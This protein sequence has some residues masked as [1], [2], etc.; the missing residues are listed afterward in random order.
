MKTLIALAV[1]VPALA[2]SSNRPNFVFILIDDLGA[3]DTSVYGSQLYPTPNIDRLAAEGMRFTQAYAAAALCSPTRASILTG[4][5][6][7]RLHVTNWIPGHIFP[8]AKLRHPDWKKRLPPERLTIA[9]ALKEHG[10]ATAMIGKWHLSGGPSAPENQ[11]F[12]VNIA[13][14]HDLLGGGLPAAA[15]YF[16]PYENP[17]LKDGPDGEYLTDR[18]TDEAI[19]WLEQTRDRP[20]FLYLSH[21]AVHTPI[22]GKPKLVAKH[23]ARLEKGQNAAYAA[24]IE[25]VDESVGRISAALDRLD[26]TANTVVV[27]FSD[28]GG[29][30]RVSSNAPLRAGKG[31]PYEG[32]IREPLIVRW[33]GEIAPGSVCDTPVISTDFFPTFLD[34]A[35]LP[36]RPEHHRDGLSLVPLLRQSGEIDRDTLYWH[37]PHYHIAPPYGVVRQNDWKLIHFDEDQ[38]S[39]LYHL[40]EDPFEKSDLAASR[41]EMVERLQAI[42]V[43]WRED[44]GAQMPTPNPDHDPAKPPNRMVDPAPY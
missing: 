5:Y 14:H 34:L 32:G 13:G 31:T 36:A 1:L 30:E 42:L 8:H 9:E 21:F 33:P 39:E 27:F 35:G 10:Y 25:S 15:R 7:A 44:V 43:K 22:K 23:R 37:F 41:P 6:P 26:L 18:L 40:A 17:H 3:R 12:D 28:N 24:M 20:F 16:S 38:R 4:Q 19:G 11:G 29:L 2:F